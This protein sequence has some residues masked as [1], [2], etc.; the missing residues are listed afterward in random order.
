MVSDAKQVRARGAYEAQLPFGTLLDD[1]GQ[2]GR[3][4]DEIE[5]LRKGMRLL[6]G[7]SFLA[8]VVS[9]IISN[10]VSNRVL[11]FLGLLALVLGVILFIYSF[12]YG[13]GLLKGRYRAVIIRDLSKTLQ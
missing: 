12:V 13:A 11:G 1:V 4:L 9:L 7:V 10:V 8:G 2:I 3:I 5:A 6:A